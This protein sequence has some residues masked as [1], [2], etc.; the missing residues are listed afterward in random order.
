MKEP[1]RSCARKELDFGGCRCQAMALAGDASATD[2]A[3]SLSPLHQQVVALAEADAASG[4]SD[5]I[6]R[7]YQGI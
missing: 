2:P 4:R 1:C 5:F 7:G 6:Y 3:C